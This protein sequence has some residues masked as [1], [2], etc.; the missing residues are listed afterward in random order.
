MDFLKNKPTGMILDGA[1]SVEAIDSSGEV[2]ELDGIDISTLEAGEGVANY[3]HLGEDSKGYGMEIVGKIIYAKKI[4]KESDCED[5][6]QRY[7]FEAVRKHPY[8]YGVVRLFDGAGHD[9][10]RA[11]AASV[12][13]AVA[14][15]EKILLRYSIEGTTLKRDGQKIKQSIAKK[16]AMTYK[17]ANKACYSGLIA[18]PN[19][20][21][22]FKVE[23][24]EFAKL[25]K[26]IEIECNPIVKDVDPASLRLLE[27]F[28]KIRAF[29]KALTAGCADVAPSGLTGGAALQKEDLGKKVS[30]Q[31]YAYIR[32]NKKFNKDGYKKFIKQVLPEVSDEYVDKFAGLAEDL[33]VKSKLKKTEPPAEPTL[34]YKLLAKA[35]ELECQVIEL[36]K[37]VHNV[38]NNVHPDIPSVYSVSLV[39]DKGVHPAGRFM[40]HGDHLHHL[41]DYHDILDTFLPEG[42]V[43][44]HTRD[45]LYSLKYSP[46]FVVKEDFVKDM[47]KETKGMEVAMKEEPAPQRPDVFHYHRPGMLNPHTLEFTPSG[48]AL[49]GQAL[50]PDEMNLIIRN[51]D[52][53]AATLKYKDVVHKSLDDDGFFEDL[54]KS[55]MDPDSALQAVRAAVAAGHMHPD[56]ERALTKHIFED[57]MIPGVGNKYAATKFLEKGKPGIYVSMDGNN[58]KAINDKHGHPAGD[59]AIS[60]VFQSMR[61]AANSVGNCKLFRNGGDEAILHA[62]TLEHAMNFVRQAQTEIDKIPATGG[63][64]KLTVAFGLGTNPKMSD[65]ALL[66]AKAKKKDSS[67]KDLYQPGK[68]P[69]LMHSLVPETTPPKAE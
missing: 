18:D 61:T 57:P 32:D 52:S 22:G 69:H 38:L 1:F 25:G 41:E 48:P 59:A 39:S 58:M 54:L 17:P 33:H 3:E 26:S 15:D 68:V 29:K 45:T 14:N 20:P 51:L 64:H 53:G 65:D 30:S 7:Y 35:A 31:T 55:D 56:V 13:D 40:V 34:E 27:T 4:F 19:A 12:R 62:P 47:P 2:V 24:P 37:N 60:G 63:T 10:A 28:C 42:P 36:R 11:L 23:N 9:G 5:E 49:D 44:D 46:R 8:L 66:L 50:S 6:R 16:V 67:G 43:T 21:E